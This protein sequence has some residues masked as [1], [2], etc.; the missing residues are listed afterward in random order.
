MAKSADINGSK[1]FS[2]AL[3]NP[4]ENVESA[5]LNAVRSIRFGSVEVVIHDSQVVQIECKNKLRIQMSTK[6]G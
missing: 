6:T 1:Q 2:M 4:S 3:E 5:I